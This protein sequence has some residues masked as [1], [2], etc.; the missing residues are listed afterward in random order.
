MRRWKKEH[1][2]N[3][4]K[5]KNESEIMTDFIAKHKFAFSNVPQHEKNLHSRTRNK[6][7]RSTQ[8]NNNEN[9]IRNAIQI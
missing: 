4:K 5:K 1:I 6:R 2:A 3:E 8:M 7:V 9:K